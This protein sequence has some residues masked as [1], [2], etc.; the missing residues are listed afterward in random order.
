MD[1]DLSENVIEAAR[2]NATEQFEVEVDDVDFEYDPFADTLEGDSETFRKSAD[3]DSGNKTLD[4]S[5]D[6]TPQGS[7]M[8]VFEDLKM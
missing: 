1:S 4:I 7:T 5:Q 3:L 2:Q 6:I 8:P